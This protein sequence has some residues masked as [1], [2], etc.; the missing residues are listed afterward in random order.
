M[1]RLAATQSPLW[2][3]KEGGYFAQ[4]GIDPDL[5]IIRGSS[6]ASAALISQ[7]VDVVEMSGPGTV[8]A[9]SHGAGIVMIAGFVNIAV[10]KLMADPSIK[11]VDDLKGK[12]IAVSQ[13]GGQDDFILRKVLKIKGLA[14]DTDVHIVA[15][16]DIPGSVAALSTHQVQ[17]AILAEPE[18]IPAQEAGAH[19]LI[20]ITGMPVPFAA[21]GLVATTSYIKTHRAAALSFIKST[22][23]GIRRIKSDRSFTDSI[24]SKYLKTTDRA[25]LDAAW[26]TVSTVLDDK[27]YPSIPGLQEVIDENKVKGHQPQEFADSSLVKELDDGGFFAQK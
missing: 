10:Y 21:T 5:S 11:T 23:Q 4:N 9:S 3:A 19:V 25:T 15:T 24:R 18:H 6:T 20:D 22:V 7:N 13:I 17:A 14:P 27:P 1:R 12:T 16:K 8:N 26:N 2:A